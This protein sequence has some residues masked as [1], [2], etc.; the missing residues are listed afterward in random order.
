[1]NREN[2]LVDGLPSK[3]RVTDQENT[4]HWLACSGV[5]PRRK[6]RV[7]GGS[8]FVAGNSFLLTAQATDAFGIPVS[9][10]P[11]SITARPSVAASVEA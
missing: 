3:H 8:T 7:V 10:G 2:N 1:M 6:V 4:G 5:W 9:N 11:T